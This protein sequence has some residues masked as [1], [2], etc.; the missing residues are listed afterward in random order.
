MVIGAGGVELP[1]PQPAIEVPNAIAT[2]ESN[3]LT[4]HFRSGLI[5][6]IPLTNLVAVLFTMLSERKDRNALEVT[7]FSYRNEVSKVLIQFMLVEGVAR[8]R[9][10]RE[11]FEA[12]G[13]SGTVCQRGNFGTHPLS[14]F[15][16]LRR[17]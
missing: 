10:E 15:G 7:S 4:A 1:S 8:L 13:S 9:P 2:S 12:L 17:L 11:R 14:L 6:R 16:T 3:T 5:I